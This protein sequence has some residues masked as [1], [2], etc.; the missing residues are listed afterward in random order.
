MVFGFVTAFI[1]LLAFELNTTNMF[2]Q[3]VN[4]TLSNITITN[5]RSSSLLEKANRVSDKYMNYEGST[6][7]NVAEAKKGVKPRFKLIKN[8]EGFES[9]LDE[10]P[11]LKANESIMEL[12]RQLRES[13]NIVTN[14]KLDHNDCVAQ[15]NY[16]VNSF[17]VVLCK[18][19]MK[20]KEFSYYTD[21]D[22]LISND[23]LG[24]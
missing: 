3:R 1:L 11:N 23:E 24:I 4:Q 18:P 13:E 7:H 21:T 2:K 8:A 16:Q 19:M 14:F 5:K 22:D 20:V 10:F 9:R 12:L 15:Y 17:P 6:V